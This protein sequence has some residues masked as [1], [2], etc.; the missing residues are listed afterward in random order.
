MFLSPFFLFRLSWK[1]CRNYFVSTSPQSNFPFTV[2]GLM[3]WFLNCESTSVFG[4]S[5]NNENFLL[6][7]WILLCS[8]SVFRFRRAF[9]FPNLL[10]FKFIQA[11]TF[12]RRRPTVWEIQLH[13]FI[14]GR[15]GS[16][17]PRSISSIMHSFLPSLSS[18]FQQSFRQCIHWFVVLSFLLSI[19]SKAVPAEIFRCTFE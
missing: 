10:I 19:S 8:R 17:F 16:S 2:D 3:P 12:T 9:S 6:L 18:L 4:V 11:T 14:T 7:L 5:N 1:A 13:S 15:F